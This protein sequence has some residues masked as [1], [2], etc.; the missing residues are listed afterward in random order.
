M[1]KMKKNYKS[2]WDV[3]KGSDIRVTGIPEGREREWGRSNILRE[4]DHE[5]SKVIRNI[6]PQI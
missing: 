5:F 3:I 1:W 6:K 2:M 4:N